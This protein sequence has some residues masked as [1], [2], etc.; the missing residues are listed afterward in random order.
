[1]A[2]PK[3]S[4]AVEKPILAERF[5]LRRRLWRGVFS[6]IRAKPLGAASGALVIFLIF[7]A[8]FADV[9]APYDPLYL[10]EKAG[11]SPPG[12]RF[13]L[14]ADHLGRD[15]LSR[16]IFGARMSLTVGTLSVI[17]GTAG[18]TVVGL[19]C[20]YLGGRTDVIIQRVVDAL[21]AFPLLILALV[22]VAMLGQSLPNV[23]LAIGF[24]IIAPNSRVIRGAVLSVKENQYV[25]AARAI[26]CSG[27]RIALLH[28]LPNVTAPIMVIAT[29]YLGETILAEAS[30]GFLG[31]GPPPP[32]PTW[33]E[34]LSGPGVGHLEKAPWL[35]VFPG[36]AISLA[37]LG[38]NLFGDALRDVLDPRLRGTQ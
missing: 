13:L 1:M 15:V 26:G 3:T 24:A 7:V 36:L 14:G 29:I 32:I 22:I 35:A 27:L 20:G 19:T 23:V 31:L 2:S 21:M 16:L 37:V 34:M 30:L 12:S 18:A 8:V 38:F 17:L 25:E 33:G 5:S 4:T 6:F 28:I 9:L 11:L 10:H